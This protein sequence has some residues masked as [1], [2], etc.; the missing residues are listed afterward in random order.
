MDV[1]HETPARIAGSAQRGAV[2]SWLGM[3]P[4]SRRFQTAAAYY[5]LGRPAYPAAFIKKVAIFCGMN[6]SHRIL[7][8]GS[9]PA[10]LA[11]AFAPFVG[12]VLA[13]DPE[14]EMLRVAR[15]A[16]N[17]A[18]VAVEV[19]EGSSET[20]GPEWGRFSAVTMGRSFHWMDRAKTLER[21]DAMLEPDGAV[22]LFND[23]VVGAQENQ[24]LLA[25]RAVV[26]RYSA[27]DKV[28]AHLRSPEGQDHEVV[29]RTSPFSRIDHIGYIH[30]GLTTVDILVHRA[31]SMSA[32][33][34][35]RLGD[36]ADHLL[37]EIRSTLAPFATDG[38]V[39]E[40][41][42]WTAIVARRP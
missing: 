29:L 5:L 35:A 16:V 25:W 6:R 10:P 28:R 31:L 4:E 22:V 40:Q 8:L 3:S 19:R 23:E 14:P 7:D 33:T 12:S 32:T 26:E 13:V 34:R 20:L 41:I 39:T 18:G 11:V 24:A 37:S 30:R 17:A 42:E 27:D 9:G 36:R 15:E 21:L 2:L 1:S 38:T